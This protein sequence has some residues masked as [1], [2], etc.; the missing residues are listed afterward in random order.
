MKKTRGSILILVLVFGS[1][2]FVILTSL[3]SFVLAENRAQDALIGK[4]ESFSIAEAGLTYYAWF[5]SHFPTDFLN[6]TGTAGPY[7][8]AYTDTESGAAGNYTLTIAG[9]SACGS[10]QIVDITST[11]V[12]SHFPS[13][14]S[15]LVARY[16]TPS[17]A[18]Y[19]QITNANIPPGVTFASINPDFAAL[20]STAQAQGIYLE[21]HAVPQDP[22]LGYHLI[23]NANGTVTIKLVTGV[24]TLRTVKPADNPGSYGK[25]T[26]YTLIGQEAD[27]QTIV[28]PSDC[29]LIFAE[30]NTW[31]E[32]VIPSKVTLVV[33]SLS[34]SGSSP[35]AILLDNITYTVNDGSVGFT[36]IGEHNILIAPNS[37]Q[38]LTLSG[39][40][41][42]TNGVFGRNNYVNPSGGCLGT[43]EPR[44]ALTI[45]GTIVSKLAPITK[46]VDGCLPGDAGYQTQTLTVDSK[47]AASPPPFTPT[48]SSVRQFIDWQQVR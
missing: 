11:G 21:A 33:G 17:V 31:I 13:M 19:A 9:S 30:D 18:A 14:L 38:N 44:G 26:D 5:L 24:T 1:I 2:F 25:G 36:V 15:T 46:W 39:V 8:V 43:Y 47:N 4:A 12:S 10:T 42:A 6:G 23:F 45:N 22:H 29:G 28:L 27:Y 48:T 3:A 41:V 20:K 40:Y 7:D 34:G 35:D 32:G 37:P 16:G